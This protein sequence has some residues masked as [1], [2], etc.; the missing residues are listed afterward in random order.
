M[1]VQPLFEKKTGR[2]LLFY[3]T[4]SRVK[5]KII[6]TCVARI[7]YL[8]E[9]LDRYPDPLAH[10]RQEA[11]RLTNEAQAQRRTLSVSLDDHFSFG[12]GISSKA[13]I[14]VQKA[15]RT[16]DYGVLPLLAL[17]RE[18]KIDYFLQIKAQYRKADVNYNHLFQLLVFG[19]ILFPA[20]KLATWRD[21]TRILQ[22]RAFSDDAVYRA[23]PFLLKS[24]MRSCGICTS[25]CCSSTNRT[26][27]FC[28]TMSRTT[29]GKWTGRTNLGSE[30]CPRS[31]GRNPSCRWACFWT[32]QGCL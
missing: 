9:F 7:G 3:Y 22:H 8:D 23:L 28:T 32:T 15:D 31:I 13:G 16:Y 25:R 27:A 20:S 10:F 17:Y 30:G 14:V 18:L 6:K 4:A 1:Y 29:T 24:R 5:G 2:T 12:T 21:R 26:Q 19:R 11:K